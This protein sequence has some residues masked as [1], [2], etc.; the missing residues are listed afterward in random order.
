MP[1]WGLLAYIIYQCLALI[2]GF[3]QHWMNIIFLLDYNGINLWSWTVNRVTSPL[4]GKQSIICIQWFLSLG[5]FRKI[6]LSPFILDHKQKKVKTQITK[7]K[8]N[9]T[10][11]LVWL[12]EISKSKLQFTNV[13]EPGNLYLYLKQ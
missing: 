9:Q 3:A 4:G 10:S 7:K 11:L 13:L 6:L 2:Y 5:C 12:Y 8:K 1:F